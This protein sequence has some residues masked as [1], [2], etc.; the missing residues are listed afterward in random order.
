MTTVASILYCPMLAFAKVSI[1]ILYHRLG[2]IRWFR[3]TIYVSMFIVI[4]AN[5]SIIF[6]FIFSCS[7]FKRGWDVTITEGH[8]VNH[9]ALYIATAVINMATDLILLVLPIPLARKLQMPTIQ[10]VGLVILF[11]VGS[12]YVFFR[13]PSSSI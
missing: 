12:A 9:A 13:S 1:L 4:A 10:K 11:G 7:P 5:F 6:P 2:P 8:C 3:I